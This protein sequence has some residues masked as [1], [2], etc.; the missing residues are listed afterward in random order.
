M[1]NEGHLEV[2]RSGPDEEVDRDTIIEQWCFP[3]RRQQ[4]GRFESGSEEDS[5]GPISDKLKT[6]KSNVADKRCTEKMIPA[7]RRRLVATDQI[8]RVKQCRTRMP[9]AFAEF[10]A[11]QTE[12]ADHN[13]GRGRTLAQRDA[14]ARLASPVTTAPVYHAGTLNAGWGDWFLPW[15]IKS[16]APCSRRIA[17]SMAVQSEL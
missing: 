15:G 14:T 4:A 11:S 17:N 16:M 2:R 9:R 3:S 10:L 7:K 1:G 13:Q 8:H 5:I 12:L 6:V